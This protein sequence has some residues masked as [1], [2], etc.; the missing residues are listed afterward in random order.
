[1]GFRSAS[2][3]GGIKVSGIRECS[4]DQ[5]AEMVCD[6]IIGVGGTVVKELVSGRI[7]GCGVGCLLGA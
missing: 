4:K 7:V 2:G 6:A 1:M 5:V 3:V